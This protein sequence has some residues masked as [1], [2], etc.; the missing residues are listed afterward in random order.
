MGSGTFPC[1]IST[2]HLGFLK[3]LHEYRVKKVILDSSKRGNPTPQDLIWLSHQVAPILCDEE[4]RQL[5]VVVPKDP[6]HARNL[7]CC[8]MTSEVCYELQFFYASQDALEWLISPS[9]PQRG[10]AVA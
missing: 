7:E 2:G 8:L 4:V 3:L 10:R 5:A 6:N 9:Q 1:Q